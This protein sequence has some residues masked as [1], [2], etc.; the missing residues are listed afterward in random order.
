MKGKVG[1]VALGVIIVLALILAFI[2]TTRIP[3]GYVGVIYSMNGGVAED[4]LGQGVIVRDYPQFAA[5][6]LFNFRMFFNTENTEDTEMNY[7]RHRVFRRNLKVFHRDWRMKDFG[8]ALCAEPLGSSCH[9]S[10]LCQS[11]T[12]CPLSSLC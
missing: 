12:L 11:K 3:A 4:T 1:G 10:R 2:C 5:D 6:N 7:F 8:A 9:L